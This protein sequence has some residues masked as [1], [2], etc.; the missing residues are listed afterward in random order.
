MLPLLLFGILCLISP[1]GATT[2]LRYDLE[3]LAVNAERV[4]VGRCNSAATELIDGRIY[5]RYRF[6]VAETV[7]GD[8]SKEIEIHLPGGTYQERRFHIIGMP[9]FSPGE[10]LVLFLTERNQLGHAWPV[11]L[12]QGRF[13]IERAGAAKRPRVF[14]E[15]DGLSFYSAG[16][17]SAAKKTSSLPPVQGLPLDEFLARV[18]ALIA[19]SPGSDDDVR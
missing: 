4:F 8:I 11:G 17:A 2:L 6:G 19:P 14:Q 1:L 10:E 12:G 7:K 18:R 9:I 13:R 3:T 16:A 15:L 5:T